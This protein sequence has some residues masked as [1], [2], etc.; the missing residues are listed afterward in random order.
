MLSGAAGFKGHLQ[1]ERLFC[2]ASSPKYRCSGLKE[3]NAEGHPVSACLSK[4]PWPQTSIRKQ[5]WFTLA[6]PRPPDQ[7]AETRWLCKPGD[8]VPLSR[9]FPVRRQQV[10][11]LFSSSLAWVCD[12]GDV[13]SRVPA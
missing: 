5:V 6:H 13:N 8:H 7:D 4:G 11:G 2:V 3:K 12:K 10:N 9:R 1:T